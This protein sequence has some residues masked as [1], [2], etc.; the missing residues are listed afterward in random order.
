MV[1]S[2]PLLLQKLPGAAIG[3]VVIAYSR[4]VYC[5]CSYLLRTSMQKVTLE[6][7]INWI[8]AYKKRYGKMLPVPDF[9]QPVLLNCS[10]GQPVSKD[11]KLR[12]M[13]GQFWNGLLPSQKDKLSELVGWL[14]QDPRDYVETM[15][16]ML[17]KSK[18][19]AYHKQEPS[20]L[21]IRSALVRFMASLF[22]GT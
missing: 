8:D 16:R 15:R 7:P 11:I 3:S 18:G 12:P 9:L 2:I 20:K 1:S 4:I 17:P 19:K 13:S 10:A 22:T 14:G 6:K 21:Y 5:C